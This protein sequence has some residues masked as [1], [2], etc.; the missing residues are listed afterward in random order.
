M[1]RIT[2]KA[3]EIIGW[4]IAIP[5]LMLMG[6]TGSILI[7]LVFS[8]VILFIMFLVMYILNGISV[9]ERARPT[10]DPRGRAMA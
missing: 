2:D 5:Y 3:L 1:R 8:P 10:P 9:P 6:V 7:I 4:L